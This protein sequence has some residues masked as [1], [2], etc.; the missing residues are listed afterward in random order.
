MFRAASFDPTESPMPPEL[1]EFVAAIDRL[2]GQSTF[3]I[4]EEDGP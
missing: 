1:V 2:P 3:E 4:W